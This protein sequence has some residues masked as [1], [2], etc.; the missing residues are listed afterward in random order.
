MD[1]L[2]TKYGLLARGD[3]LVVRAMAR[4]IFSALQHVRRV[5]RRY[6][7]LTVERSNMRS[8]EETR[9]ERL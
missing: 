2:R 4:F 7:Y 1:K 6:H 5:T 9:L 8:S 3:R